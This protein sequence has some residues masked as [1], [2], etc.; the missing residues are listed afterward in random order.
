MRAE[1]LASLPQ[2]TLVG[3]VKQPLAEDSRLIPPPE[4]RAGRPLATSSCPARGRLA[5]GQ[6][7]RSLVASD[8]DE[9]PTADERG[10]DGES[11]RQRL[12]RRAASLKILPA[13]TLER[14]T[15]GKRHSP[16][17]VVR[18]HASRQEELLLPTP[19]DEPGLPSRHRPGRSRHPQPSYRRRK[20]SPPTIRQRDSSASDDR[21]R[22]ERS[23]RRP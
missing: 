15:A 1:E 13:C 17:P 22:S 3:L 14:G 18:W 23:A 19:P 8:E 21:L 7:H 10:R 4:A 20:C 11:D 5:R 6:A 16:L 9:W 2:S 12:A